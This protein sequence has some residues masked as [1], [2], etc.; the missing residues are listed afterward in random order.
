MI[1]QQQRAHA[2]VLS[3][4]RMVGPRRAVPYRLGHDAEPDRLRHLD[5]TAKPTRAPNKAAR[6]PTFRPVLKAS[7]CVPVRRDAPF[8]RVLAQDRDG[9][10]APPTRR[11]IAPATVA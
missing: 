5:T 7:G 2:G 6:A 4:P 1:A 8:A 11:S 3:G 9:R 10:A